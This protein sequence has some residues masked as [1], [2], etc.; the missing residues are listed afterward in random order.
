MNYQAVYDLIISRL[1]AELSS[2]LSYHSVQHTLDVIHQSER[3]A[4]IMGIPEK[5][6]LTLKTAALFHDIGYVYSHINHEEKSCSIAREVLPQFDYD[7]TEIENIC[8]MI[9]ATNIPQAPNNILSKILCDADM[10]Y[11]GTDTYFEGA[12]M[13]YDEYIKRGILKDHKNWKDMQIAFLKS[14]SFHTDIV[15]KECNEM[16]DK[17]LQ[18][19]MNN[20]NVKLENSETRIKLLKD[21]LKIIIGVLLAGFGLKGFLVPNHFFD[22]GNTGIS[23]LLKQVVGLDL[24][25]LLLFTNFPFIIIG[26]FIIGRKFAIRTLFSLI[27][28]GLFILFVPVHSMTEDKLLIAIFGGAFLGIGTGLVMRAGGALDGLEVLALY[29][30]RKTSFSMSEV[31]L[32]INFIIFLIAGICFGF[33]IALYSVLTYLSATKCIDYVV[34]GIHAYTGVTIISS[35]SNEIKLEVVNTLGRAITVYKGERGFLPGQFH[36]HSEVDIIFTI[37]NRLELRKLNNLVKTIDPKAFIYSNT[38]KEV[39]GGIVKLR[40]GH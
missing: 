8:T 28:L 14:H 20:N 26:Y 10:Y 31:I 4:N 33:E 13:L 1:R 22:G 17:N 16:K 35:K 2:Q 15:Q 21:F 39:S 32:G 29:T 38:I 18:E 37:I 27:L 12:E 30:L 9:M 6:T 7:S 34:E 19:I 5:E 23:L 25:I 36:I 11:L 3:I 24:S 40:L